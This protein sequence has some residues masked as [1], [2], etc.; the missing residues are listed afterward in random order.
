VS[1]NNSRSSVVAIT[2]SVIR[3]NTLSG[4]LPSIASSSYSSS[5]IS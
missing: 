5:G 3:R 1:R 2:G 4:P